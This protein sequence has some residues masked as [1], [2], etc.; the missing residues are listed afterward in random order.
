M[1]IEE[2]SGILILYHPEA[3]K[4]LPIKRRLITGNIEDFRPF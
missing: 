3:L 4:K 2:M 1:G